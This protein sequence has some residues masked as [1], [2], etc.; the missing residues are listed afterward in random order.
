MCHA[1]RQ[2]LR[3]TIVLAS[4]IAASGLF[5]Q[6]AQVED[7]CDMACHIAATMVYN[8]VVGSV[9]VAQALDDAADYKEGCLQAFCG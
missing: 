7:D 6:V 2:S 1:A 5:A 9:G 4:L 3:K 8:S